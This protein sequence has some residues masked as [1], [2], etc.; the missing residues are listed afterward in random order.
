[1][2][3]KKSAISRIDSQVRSPQRN[4]AGRPAGY[5]RNV[6]I[7]LALT[8]LVSDS[9][10]PQASTPK[11]LADDTLEDLMNIEVT[12]VSRKE[13][14]LSKT[15]AAVYVINQED[16]RRSGATNIPD[17]LRMAPGVD[18]AQIDANT[19]AISIRG[20]N[21]RLANAVL[22][23]IDGRTVY[24][25]TTSGVFW[26][27]LDVPLPDIDR[28]EI[29]R[30]PGGTVWGANAV[31]GVINIITKSAEDTRG[32]VVSGGGGSQGKAQGLAQ[33]GGGA[34]Q[35][36][37]YRVFGDYSNQGNLTASNGTSEAADGWHMFHGGF[38]SDWM[39]SPADSLTVQGDFIQTSEGQ[40]ISVVFANQLPLQRTF[41][42]AVEF[43]SGNVLARWSHKL[44]N[45]S[46]MALQ[47]YFDRYNRDDLGISEA[48]NTLDL[49]FQH[50]LKVRTR[51]DIVWGAGYRLMADD[52][53]DGYG[54]TYVPLSL[55]NSLLSTFIQDEIALS[56]S[57]RLT[58]GSKFEHVPYSGF[59]YEPSAK[60]L[61]QPTQRQAIWV[62]A[63]RA[64]VQPSREDV[65]LRVDQY[66]F[67]T[68]GGGF[69]VSEVIGNPN[70]RAEQL[71]DF[72]AG[73][74]V[75]PTREFSLDLATFSSYYRDLLTAVPEAPFLN[76]GP[77]PS[78]LIFPLVFE[79]IAR[80]HTYGAEAAGT[81]TVTRSWRIT[82]SLSAIHLA[83][84]NNAGG[85]NVPEDADN[86]PQ[87]QAQIRSSL[88]LT[89]H[90][91]WDVALWHIGRLRDGGDG[92]VPAYN[93]VDTRLAWRVGKFT[94]FSVVGQNLLTPLHAEF[95]NAYEVRRTLVERS[96]FGK[97]TW[98]F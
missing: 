10:R 30:G 23:L 92:A 24:T 21:D 41:N 4:R 75:Q 96:V 57:L 15:A 47:V 9:A 46:A 93:R 52:H 38:R 73:Y 42:D 45:G 43:D 48:L 31:N 66:T 81:W 88:D 80:A 11:A 59:D 39:L 84:S 97:I 25:P 13:Q 95:H 72:E 87:F 44:A 20:F 17:L 55:T 50:H 51:H 58:L 1:L 22:V 53:S 36:G 85:T 12:S 29:T 49:D 98:R 61:W 56:D 62:S 16:I 35:I 6:C 14:K 79:N 78:Y 64:I 28:I 91:D 34:G 83:T 18:V 74:R 8:M 3:L 82:P 77:E 86:T 63:S 65:S 2:T 40:T 68:P 7:A 90:L 60:I 32:A 71:Y 67:P 26:D 54:K 27:E 70:T 33:Y 69:G 89:K 5:S 94:E 19:W 76:P 37:A